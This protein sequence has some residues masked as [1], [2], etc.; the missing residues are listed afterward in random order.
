LIEIRFHGRGG[1]G[2]VVASNILADAAFREGKYVQ[3]FP[4]FGVERRGAPVTS[5][6]RI[7]KNPIKIRSQVYSPNYIVVLD[8]TLMDVTDVTSGLGKSGVVLIN[9]DKDP[10]YYN[11]SFKTATIDATSIALENK[12]GSKMAPIVNTSIL[13]AF[14]KISGEVMLESIILAIK[15]NIPSKK[16]ENIKAATQAYDKTIM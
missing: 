12:L 11:L 6:T 13:G 7:D 8:P 10:K 4:Y 14:A 9:S 16:E 2:A 3:A 5:F 1:Q 15:E